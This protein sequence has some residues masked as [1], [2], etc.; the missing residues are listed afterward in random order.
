MKLTRKSLLFF[1][2]ILTILLLFYV[3]YDFSQKN[4]GG[5]DSVPRWLGTK[6]FF[7]EGISPYSNIVS[8]RSQIFITGRLAEGKEDRQLFVYPFYV[9]IFYLPF[10]WLPFN[11]A[12][13]IW[14]VLTELSIIGITIFSIKLYKWNPPVW[15]LGISI[16]LSLLMYNS[17]RTIILWQMAGL[18]A[19]LII[20]SIWALKEKK[21]V[22]A[23]IAMALATIKP[24]MVFLILPLLV[25]WTLRYRRRFVISLSI[26]LIILIG[27][28]FVIE[29]T[30]VSLMLK[31]I[32]DYPDYTITPS[33][34]FIFSG[35]F[36]VGLNIIIRWLLFITLFGWMLWEWKIVFFEKL[37]IDYAIALSLLITNIIIIRTAT[38]NYLM[39]LPVFFYIFSIAEKEYS[40]LSYL[41]VLGMELT[42]FFGAWIIFALT[43]NK[44]VE[45]WPGYF[46]MPVL[47]MCGL[48]WVR[49]I[50][51]S[52]LSVSKL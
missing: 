8:E 22:L 13:A 25:I 9:V 19:F 40:K 39:M 20:F 6:A 17:I 14:M 44:G 43:V 36:P 48:I 42:Y 45:T 16:G 49:F 52:N 10:I 30:W 28:S 47:L 21:D 37:N 26:T 50:R 11:V 31:Q 3:N 1:A 7:Y 29:P 35:L 23:G 15:L 46:P 5:A 32:K 4:P 24:Q 18:V 12:R 2:F 33:I 38:T 27:I 41:P 51:K 34:L